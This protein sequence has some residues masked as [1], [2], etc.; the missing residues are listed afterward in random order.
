MS[1][2]PFLPGMKLTPYGVKDDPLMG[3]AF[4]GCLY[5]AI[6]QSDVVAEFEKETGETLFQARSPTERMVDK[7]TGREADLFAR[8]ADFVVANYWGIE[9]QEV[10]E[11]AR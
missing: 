3:G 9:G 1:E 11:A 6:R 10:D 7:A 5:W 4:V 8:F 2:K